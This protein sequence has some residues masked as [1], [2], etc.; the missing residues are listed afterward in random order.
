MESSF[1]TLKMNMSS[2]ES[3]E[4]KTMIASKGDFKTSPNSFPLRLPADF[5]LTKVWM[6][7]N[8]QGR[9]LLVLEGLQ[10]LYDARILQ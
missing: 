6:E 7:N 3:F 9:E 4:L 2:K 5:P 8:F 1:A 10:F